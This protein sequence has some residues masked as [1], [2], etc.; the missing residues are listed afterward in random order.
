MRPFLTIGA[1]NKDIKSKRKLF[2][3]SFSYYFETFWCF[4][5]FSFHHKWNDARLLLINIVYTICLTNWDL[6]S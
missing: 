4:T 5:K 6:G 3:Q 2:G 1:V